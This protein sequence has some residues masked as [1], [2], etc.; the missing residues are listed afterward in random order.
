MGPDG[1]H[2]QVLRELAGVIAELLLAIHQQSWLTGEVS[3]DWRL[4]DV[5]P[6]FKKG[7]KKDLG[8]ISLLA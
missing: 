8:T 7:H 3:E 5:T 1:L 6:I 4:A 2:P